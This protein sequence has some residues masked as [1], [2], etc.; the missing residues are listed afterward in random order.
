VGVSSSFL[1][2]DSGF[3][4]AFTNRKDS[5]NNNPKNDPDNV[6][7]LKHAHTSNILN[8]SNLFV[9][10]RRPERYT[11]VNESITFGQNNKTGLQVFTTCG[12]TPSSSRGVEPERVSHFDLIRQRR[13]LLSPQS[14]HRKC[15]VSPTIVGSTTQF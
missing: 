7:R 2:F 3:R 14:L 10:K 4:N 9:K 11:D 15:S 5:G 1:A 6:L 13:A 12:Y 8:H